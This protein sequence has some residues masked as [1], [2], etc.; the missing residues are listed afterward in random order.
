MGEQDKV[1]ERYE[2]TKVLDLGPLLVGYSTGDIFLYDR[3]TDD[4]GPV[5]AALRKWL[6]TGVTE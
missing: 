6:T 2:I 5:A 3:K 1:P 4:Q